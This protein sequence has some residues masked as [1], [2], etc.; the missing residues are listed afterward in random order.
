MAI[1]LSKFDASLLTLTLGE[2]GQVLSPHYK[3]QWQA[4]LAGRGLPA[5][6][7]KVEAK[8]TLTFLP[9]K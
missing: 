7:N 8:A 2:S 1:D 5:Q 9:E 3:D 6:F 4:Y